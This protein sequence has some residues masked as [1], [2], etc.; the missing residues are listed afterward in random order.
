LNENKKERKISIFSARVLRFAIYERQSRLF[1]EQAAL[2]K[3]P[4]KSLLSFIRI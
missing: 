1:L 4:G 3:T 2:I